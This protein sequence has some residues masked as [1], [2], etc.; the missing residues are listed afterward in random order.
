MDLNRLNLIGSIAYSQPI[1]GD[2][3]STSFDYHFHADYE[4]TDRLSPMVEVNGITY[5]SDGDTLPFNFEGNDLINLGSTNVD[6]NTVI[7]G[8]VGGRYQF[9]DC[10]FGISY[11]WPLTS[12]Q[13]LLGNRWTFDFV[14]PF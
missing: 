7:T 4:L 2:E 11:E 13:D 3:E 1:D 14:I 5:V 10:S 8:A 6:G 9:E 12:R